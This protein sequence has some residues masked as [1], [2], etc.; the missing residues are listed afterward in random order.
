M[1]FL[2]FVSCD[3][4]LGRKLRCDLRKILSDLNDIWYVGRGRH[5]NNWLAGRVDRQSRTGLIFY[6]CDCCRQPRIERENRRRRFEVSAC[7]LVSQFDHCCSCVNCHFMSVLCK[8]F[9][10]TKL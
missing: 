1:S 9:S 4:E 3:F 10:A 7:F 2:V 8:F 5:N 6:C